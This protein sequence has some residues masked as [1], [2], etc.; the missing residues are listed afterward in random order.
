MSQGGA[1]VSSLESQRKGSLGD[2]VR[3]LVWGELLLPIAPLVVS[4]LGNPLMFRRKKIHWK[5]RF[6][7]ACH[8]EGIPLYVS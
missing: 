6:E 4:L 8:K 5:R 3:G 7:W 1:A 2:R